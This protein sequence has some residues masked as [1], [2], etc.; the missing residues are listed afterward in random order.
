MINTKTKYPIVLVHGLFGFS[1]ICGI[2]PYFYGIEEALTKGGAQVFIP[3]LSAVNSNEV[4][5]EQLLSFVHEVLQESGAEKVNLIGHS[6]GA[7]TSRYVAATHP[8]L[9]ASVTSVNGVNFGSEIADFL[10]KAIV[11]GEMSESLAAGVFSA[12]GAFLSLMSGRPFLKQDAKDAIDSLTTEGV[13]AFNVKYPQ[14]LPAHWGGE[15]KEIENGVYYFSWGGIIKN[16]VFDQSRN[17]LDPLHG[18]MVTLSTFF[19]NERNQNDGLV[20]RYS[21]HLG[22]VIRSDYSMDHMD[23]VNQTAGMV[24][25]SVNPVKLYVNHAQRLREKGL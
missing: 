19:V 16:G 1:K 4:R 22:K 3:S 7:L 2:Y 15:G 11:P 10:R 17:R 24:T 21:M 12:F 20:G 18:A 14:G 5:G 25:T 23:A 13:A 8:E 6:Q 9:I